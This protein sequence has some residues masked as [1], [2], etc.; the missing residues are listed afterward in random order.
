MPTVCFRNVCTVV[1]VGHLNVAFAIEGEAD[2]LLAIC[3]YRVCLD[4]DQQVGVLEVAEV[5]PILLAFM[6]KPSL[7][8][9]RNIQIQLSDT[10]VRGSTGQAV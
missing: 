2:D 7:N 3:L 4:L 1:T 9:L 10:T 6:T 8:F 5:D